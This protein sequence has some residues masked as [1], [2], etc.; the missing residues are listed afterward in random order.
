[1]GA[2]NSAQVADLIGI[3]ILDMLGCIVKLRAD[4]AL[5]FIGMMGLSSSCIVKA[6]KDRT[7]L[8]I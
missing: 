1:M 7:R 2:Y 3:Y 5:G 8:S 6:P 4:G